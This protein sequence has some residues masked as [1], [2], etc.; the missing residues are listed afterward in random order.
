[1][2]ENFVIYNDALK[3]GLGIVLMQDEKVI[4]YVFFLLKG[5]E[6]NYPTQDLELETILFKLNLATLFVR[7]QD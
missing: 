6:R 1:M 4:A 5:H 2:G 3:M 7:G